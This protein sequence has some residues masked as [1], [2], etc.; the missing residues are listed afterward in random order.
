MS[1]ESDHLRRL[2]SRI[3]KVV[4]KIPKGHVA[5]YGQVAELAG[6]PG[7]ARVAGAAMKTSRPTDAVPWQ[8][9]IGKAGKTRGRIAIHDP[10]GAAVQRQLLEDEGVSV[11]DSGLVALDRFGWLPPE[12]R[13][14]E[15]R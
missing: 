15:G 14:L 13:I 5:T 4:R 7:G 2:Y 6:L 12:P 3:Y 8:R 1:D 10:V 9:V 11:G